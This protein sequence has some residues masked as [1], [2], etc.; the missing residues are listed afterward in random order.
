MLLIQVKRFSRG[1]NAIFFERNLPNPCLLR[2][3]LKIDPSP[4]VLFRRTS[5]DVKKKFV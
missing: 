4:P 5:V 1:R 3:D 2:S